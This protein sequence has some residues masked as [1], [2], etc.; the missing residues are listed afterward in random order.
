M[1]LV[2][3]IVAPV[4]DT[5]SSDVDRLRPYT[6]HGIE[7]HGNGTVRTATCPFC[8]KD[9]KWYA[10]EETG[11]WHCF[12]CKEQGNAITFLRKLHE[13]SVA[14]TKHAD[15]AMLA[16]ERKLAY[17]A[18]V[19]AWGAC[20]SIVDTTWLVPG[21]DVH[22]KLHQLYKRVRQVKDGAWVHVLL[23]TPGIWADGRS[24][25]I[26]MAVGSFNPAKPNALVLEGPWDG[27]AWWETARMSK[28]I[29][30][31]LEPT[32]Q[33]SASLLKDTNVFA[34]PGCT[35]F[36]DHWL[37]LFRS[38]EVAFGF[39]SDHPRVVN[40]KTYRAAYDSVKRNAKKV[41]GISKT[42]SWIRW[43]D[44]GYDQER[45]SGWDVR[46]HITQSI[47]RRDNLADL[48][49]KIEIVP[50]EWST[51][52]N[53]QPHTNGT[54]KEIS[55]LECNNWNK[56]EQAWMEAQEWR[57]IAADV[58]SVM[59]AV[60]A[61]TKQAGGQLFLQ[62]IGS[63]S[64]GK[65]TFCDGLLVSNTCHSLEHL[66]GFHSGWKKPGDDTKDCSLIARINGKTLI[67]PEGDVLM[68]SPK[69][70]EIMSQCRRIFDGTSGATF[71]NDDVDRL[72]VGLRTPWIMA[73]T[74]ALMDTD[75]SRLGDRFMRIIFTD[76]TREEKRRICFK[77]L[78]SELESM[79]ETSN[80]TAGSVL[81]PKLR[82]AHALTGGYVD[83]LR[84]NI[85]DI[86]PTIE[87]PRSA[88]E[89]FVNLSEL[90]ADLRA[91]PNFDPRKH[92]THDNKEMPYRISCQIGRLAQCL[93]AARN[94]KTIDGSILH[95][96]K[97]VAMDTS[98]GHTLNIVRWLC[99]VHQRTGRPTQERGLM[100]GEMIDWSGMTKEKLERYLHF[101]RNIDVLTY[102]NV[103]GTHGFYRLTD[104]VFDLYNTIGIKEE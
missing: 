25:G 70:A 94:K 75:Q 52:L 23:P 96:V 71:K 2:P 46:D 1:P 12:V 57:S 16:S 30:G 62:V 3:R 93:A 82:R 65:T 74:Q 91:R 9:K 47:D 54:V 13:R 14:T 20:R 49:T 59:L 10:S 51:Q 22:G 84:N 21:Y 24:H 6:F 69:F 102:D 63:A 17:P 60:C 26:H 38:K 83:W 98:Y 73:G 68:S 99:R 34:V 31:T 39:D 40:G 56:L 61:S 7:L 27:M 76:P 36:P 19:A 45:K 103:P 5:A 87:V 8:G 104:R 80:G 43:G 79:M 11:R 78:D 88:K 77:A 66:S 81:N 42:V 50:D 29:D 15:L 32:G 100:L 41:S 44:E 64:S 86:L 101:L 18:T 28:L 35:T 53:G 48:M 92:E 72:Y 97:K 95:I 89:M 58:L 90:T 67:T 33:E 37:T 4:V 55:A 85:E